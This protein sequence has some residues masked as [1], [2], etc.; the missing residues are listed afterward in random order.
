MDDWKKRFLDAI[1]MLQKKG[2]KITGMIISPQAN[3]MLLAAGDLDV[4]D[5]EGYASLMV[6]GG[7]MVD[8]RVNLGQRDPVIVIEYDSPERIPASMAVHRDAV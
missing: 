5:A 1:Y 4:T 2:H 6:I 7:V 3:T 8:I